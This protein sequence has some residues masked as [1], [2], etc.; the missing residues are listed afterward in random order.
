METM[1]QRFEDGAYAVN[2]DIE[3]TRA[4]YAARAEGGTDECTCTY[5]KNFAASRERA[6]PAPFRQLL[7]LLG[8]DYKKEEETWHTPAGSDGPRHFYAG[9]FDFIG[10]VE[11]PEG[12]PPENKA[13]GW[14][15]YW[16]GNS[17]LYPW[18]EKAA[19]EL[20]LGPVAHVGFTV[21][22]PWI[23]SQAPEPSE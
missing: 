23:L 22:L 16:F 12:K 21:R 18:G 6:Y 17:A 7:E 1:I 8:I 19:K 2:V 9:G 11:L 14:L 3:A 10:S 15:T 4:L 5:C 13:H 20:K